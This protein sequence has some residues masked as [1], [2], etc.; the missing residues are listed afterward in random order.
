MTT[1]VKLI[2]NWLPIGVGG[3]INDGEGVGEID[4]SVIPTKK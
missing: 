2:V 1:S 4:E 3:G